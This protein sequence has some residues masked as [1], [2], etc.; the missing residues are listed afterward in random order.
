MKEVGNVL[1]TQSTKD[2]EVVKA[3]LERISCASMADR[4]CRCK[5][6]RGVWARVA[7]NELVDKVEPNPAR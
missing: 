1:S 6:S 4:P 7:S 3:M 5:S 2:P